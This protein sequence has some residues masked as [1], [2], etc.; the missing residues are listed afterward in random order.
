MN[1]AETGLKLPVTAQ[2]PNTPIVSMAMPIGTRRK[3]RI[4]TAGRPRKP[5]SRGVIV[6]LQRAWVRLPRSGHS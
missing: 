3:I 4:R 1:W 6:R 2:L 5:S